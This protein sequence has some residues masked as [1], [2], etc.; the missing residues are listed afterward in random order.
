MRLWVKFFYVWYLQV[1]FNIV[2]ILVYC[3]YNKQQFQGLK[4]ANRLKYFYGHLSQ[5]GNKVYFLFLK[6]KH[7]LHKGFFR[8]KKNLSVYSIQGYSRR[9][10]G[11]LPHGREVRL[12]L[13]A[14]KTTHNLQG[15]DIGQ[16]NFHGSICALVLLRRVGCSLINS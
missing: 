1:F 2:M 3:K 15:V 8:R 14:R 4:T 11:L 6:Q 7:V 9:L 5:A 13:R 10:W 12:V 16:A